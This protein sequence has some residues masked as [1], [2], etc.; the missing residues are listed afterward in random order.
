MPATGLSR[1]PVSPKGHQ[2]RSPVLWLRL[3]H[4][5]SQGHV[6]GLPAFLPGLGSALGLISWPPAALSPPG[7]PTRVAFL[8]YGFLMLPTY[9]GHSAVQT[10]MCGYEPPLTPAFRLCCRCGHAP[11][12]LSMLGLLAGTFHHRT[13]PCPGPCPA[14]SSTA[15]QS[16]SHAWAL[17]AREVGEQPPCLDL[18]LLIC[19]GGA[20]TAHL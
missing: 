9:T 6:R 19:T 20:V 2:P 3:P 14:P 7:P 17:P 13:H 4:P 15:A 10:F 5:C 8:K 18:R 11:V 16:A 1:W 12:P